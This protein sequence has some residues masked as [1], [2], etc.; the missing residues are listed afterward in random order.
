MSSNTENSGEVD[1][2][3]LLLGS[4]ADESQNI[5]SN[6]TFHNG[7]FGAYNPSV[8]SISV[9]GFKDGAQAQFQSQ[10]YFRPQNMLGNQIHPQIAFNPLLLNKGQFQ[11]PS[12]QESLAP[13]P[14]V[15]SSS[16]NVH[17]QYFQGNPVPSPFFPIIPMSYDPKDPTK[18]RN[19]RPLHESSV[20]PVKVQ[21]AED[22]KV[23]SQEED[24]K[25]TGASMKQMTAADKRRY[26]RNQREQ[27]RSLKISQQINDL[28]TV[29]TESKL[30]FKPNKI[31][32]LINV[33]EYIKR[34]K[35]KSAQLESEHKKLLDTLETTSTI[36]TSGTAS[37]IVSTFDAD[38]KPETPQAVDASNGVL[39]GIN[40]E[41]MFHSCNIG[42]GVAALDGRFLDCNEVFER[43]SGYSKEELKHSSLFHLLSNNAMDDVYRVLV[44]ML[45]EKNKTNDF[46]SQSFWCGIVP[47]KN[48]KTELVLN[49]TLARSQDGIPKYFNFALAGD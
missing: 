25:K 32:I 3:D 37:T 19:K 39:D 6:Q 45:K 1:A 2:I 49:I 5:E 34:L 4:F 38:D 9:D 40:F 33:V 8:Q 12:L 47:K 43:V 14:Q 29:L 15:I 48:Q 13:N 28:R 17:G 21:V 46:T 10:Y 35:M 31:S 23:S 7:P 30:Q 16:A 41:D 22:S 36:V 20:R 27:Q 42:L 44:K 18:V 24:N 26:D 11:M